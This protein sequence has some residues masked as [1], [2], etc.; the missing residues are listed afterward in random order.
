MRVVFMGTP[1]FAVPS[2]KKLAH[3]HQ[4]SLVITRPDAVRG[5]GKTLEASPVKICAQQLGLRVIEANRITYEVKLALKDA[6]PEIICV[7]AFGC[8]LPDDVLTLVPYG[9]VN[10]HASLLPRWRG[11]APVQRAILAGDKIA[12]VSIMKI[13]HE[14]DAGDWC[15]QSTCEIG[16][17]NTEE[18][19][20]TLANLGATALS[21]SLFK[22]QDG[23]VI[24]HTQ[25]EQKVTLAPKV[26]KQEMKLSPDDSVR[27]NVLRVQA[28]SDTAPARASI[29]GRSLR[30]LQAQ[31][32][33]ETVSVKSGTAV[34]QDHK[35]Y[36]GCVDGVLEVFSVRPDGKRTMDAKSF[37]AGLQKSHLTWQKLS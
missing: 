2:L 35:L 7:V 30:V 26:T 27:Q 17:Q 3:E 4:V 37:V 5:R 6:Q 29:S 24:W 25:D 31:S 15:M 1:D 13:A 14:L 22:L 19:S 16:A 28:S 36:L 18:L 10:V 21:D 11:A 33:S 32:V 12:G 9:A 20:Q 34:V 8:I 23:S